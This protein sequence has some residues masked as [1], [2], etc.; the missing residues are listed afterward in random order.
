MK[1]AM[2]GT[3]GHMGSEALRQVLEINEVEF[4]RILLVEGKQNDRL[5]KRL[6]RQYGSRIQIVRGTVADEDVCKRLVDGVEYVVHMAAVIP[7]LSDANP[8]ASEECNKLGA[9]AV[10]DSVRSRVPQP[11]YIHISTVALYGH[12]N[13]KHPFGRVGDPLL[14]S[15]YDVYAMHKLYGERYCLDAEL[16]C[17]VI[18]R[19]TAML[20]SDMLRDHLRDGLIFHTALNAPLEWVSARD[21]GYLIRCILERDHAEGIPAFWNNIYN[22]GAGQAGRRTGVDTFDDGF[23]L[24][25][26][27]AEK[28]LKP[29]WFAT[30]NFHGMWFSD[31]DELE[32]LFHYQRDSVQEYWE[33]IGRHHKLF[34][35]GR[36]I[37]AKLIERFLFQRLTRHP[38]SPCRWLA[39]GAIAQTTAVFKSPE[40]AKKLSP[41]WSDHKLLARDDFGDYAAARSCEAAVPLAHGYDEQ[42]QLSDLTVDELCEAAEFR[43]GALITNEYC[44]AP[45][46]KLKWRCHDG[47][48]FEASPFTILRGGHWCPVCC[49]PAP[50][51][52]DRVAKYSPFHAQVWYD[53]HAPEENHVYDYDKEGNPCLSNIAGD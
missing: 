18:L 35:I 29:N 34:A 4:V 1:I 24:V 51:I 3:T 27:S 41:H 9:M 10:I 15:P 20:H 26:G 53:T 31:A 5:A 39:D 30:R 2:T 33:E 13:E 43:G 22:I 37:P 7:P 45:Y 44:R 28:F 16:D 21:S 42:K 49:Q 48:E 19:Q 47:H 40:N 11:K 46:R 14:V 6:A 25:G 12:R 32:S 50:W 52:F 38:N 8:A 23:S 17:F 36:L